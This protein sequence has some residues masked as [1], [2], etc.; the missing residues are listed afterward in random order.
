MISKMKILAVIFSIVIVGS[1]ATIAMSGD[2]ENDKEDKDFSGTVYIVHLAELDAIYDHEIYILLS[3]EDGEPIYG[4]VEILPPKYYDRECKEEWEERECKEEDDWEDEEKDREEE[5]EEKEREMDRKEEEEKEED[6]EDEEDEEREIEREEEEKE[7]PEDEEAEREEEE[8]E[9]E[10][11]EV[12]EEE[13]EIDREEEEDEEDEEEEDEE[14]DEEE[15]E[16]CCGRDRDDDDCEE[17]DREERYRKM[18][19]SRRK[20]RNAFRFSFKEG[21]G[22]FLLFPSS[23][24]YLGATAK[25]TIKSEG[26]VKLTPFIF[27]KDTD[28]VIF[29]DSE[30]E[31]GKYCEIKK[32][33][34]GIWYCFED[35]MDSPDFEI[36]WDYD[37]P[38][39]FIGKPKK[40]DFHDKEDWEKER[41]EK[42]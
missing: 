23:H 22:R 3:S 28:V 26:N 10:E 11:E 8:E 25:I 31:E 2:Q 33:E 9:H 4:F 5:G 20:G 38:V 6:P 19:E 42:R 36:D 40:E 21:K 34:K 24:R 12:P 13:R 29:P 17:R 37:D 39:L 7:E 18:G 41:K 14:E 35:L 27:V 15:C 30:D 16:G 32:D 1:A